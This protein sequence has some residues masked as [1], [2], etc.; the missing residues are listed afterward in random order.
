M[1]VISANSYLLLDQKSVNINGIYLG[2][3]KALSQLKDNNYLDDLL[4]DFFLEFTK[5]SCVGESGDGPGGKYCVL[6]SLFYTI[7]S[8]CGDDSEEYQRLRKWLKRISTPLLLSDAIVIPMYCSHISHWWLIVICH[9]HRIFEQMKHSLQKE[10][11]CQNIETSDKGWIIC[12]D[13]LGGKNIGM[14]KK[15]KAIVNILRFLDVERRSNSIY[16]GVSERGDGSTLMS[17]AND[18]EVMKMSDQM[19]QVFMSLGS[20][21]IIYNPRNLPF[22]ENK[23][24]CGIYIIEYAHW[25]FHYGTEIFNTMVDDSK[26]SNESCS[27]DLQQSWF[28]R[29]WFQNRRA[30]YSRVLEFMSIHP[31]WNEDRLLRSRLLEI[32]DDNAATPTRA[33]TTKSENPSFLQIRRKFVMSSLNRKY[34]NT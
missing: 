17:E 6:S 34:F 27:T 1:S 24:D 30:V 3:D 31:D 5:E 25:L 4:L 11:S 23:F 13:S 29:K 32:F 19:S 12:M 33:R 9:P 15:K 18:T 8:M 2:L 28:S 21:E 7:L 16:S 20:W 10:S 14:H 22:Q 26:F